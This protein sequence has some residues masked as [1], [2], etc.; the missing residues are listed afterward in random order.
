MAYFLNLAVFICIFGVSAIGLN[1]VVGWTGLLSAAQAVFA[2]IGAYAAALLMTKAGLGFFLA[3]PLAMLAA[4]AAALL[5]GVVFS[6]FRGDYYALATMGFGVI[7]SGVLL[8]WRSLTGGPFGISGIPRP[9]LFGFTLGTN[10]TFLPLALAILIGAWL[11][12]RQVTRTSFGRALSAIRED[13][14]ALKVFGYRTS[15]F[16]LVVFVLGAMLAG[17]SGAL[18]ASYLRYIEPSS[19]VLTESVFLLA[20][21]IIGGL[22]DLRGPVAGAAVM[23]LLPEALRFLGVSPSLAAQLRQ[24]LYGLALV[25]LMHARPQGIFGKYRL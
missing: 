1:L 23:I 8:N 4:G 22:A 21:V 19:F 2:G 18:F 11:V 14:T 24:M 17:A 16:K 7:M 15:H 12:A 9:S 3:L 13:E 25:V 20:I 5:V 6:R 10:A